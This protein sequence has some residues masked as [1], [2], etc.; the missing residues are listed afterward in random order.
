[1]L[2]SIIFRPKKTI[3]DCIRAFEL[4]PNNTKALYRKA[5]AHEMLNNDSSAH[6][7][8]LAAFK[9]E[10]T[11]KTVQE[12]LNKLEKKLGLKQVLRSLF[13]CYIALYVK[14]WIIS[15]NLY[16]FWW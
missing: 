13:F 5:L 11:N 9:I 2:F 8:L 16:E 14:S 3:L 6:D 15:G 4:D 10:P 12:K 7:D 1:M